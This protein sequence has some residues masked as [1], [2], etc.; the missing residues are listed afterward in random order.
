MADMMDNN[1]LDLWL[2][3]SRLPTATVQDLIAELDS[4]RQK[5]PPNR[6]PDRGWPIYPVPARTL[7]TIRD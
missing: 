2:R 3:A 6:Q 5:V 4:L 1:L 7:E